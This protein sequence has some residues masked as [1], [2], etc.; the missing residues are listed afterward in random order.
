VNEVA[1]PVD[2]ATQRWGIPDALIGWVVVF[3]AA[4]IWAIV[5]IVATGHADESFDEL[6][7][8]IVALVQLGL[9]TGFF[10]VPWVV[11]KT[12]GNGM[13]AD[14]GVRATWS[15][16]GLGV[17]LGVILQFLLIP[18]YW[19][20]LEL[21]DKS[22]DDLEG[23]AESLTDRANTPIDVIFLV[24]IVGV[25]A[26]IFEEIFYRGLLQRALL[27]RGLGPVLS[28]GLTSVFFGVTHVEPLQTVGLILA[29]ALFGTLAYRTGRLGPAIAAHVGF[30]MVTVI[31]LLSAA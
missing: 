11:T 23:V 9:A 29:G 18:V 28:V 7:L 20:I 14:L 27:K 4:N 22:Y 10:V 13:V 5:V 31:S 8:A 2:E 17:P 19:P 1:T 30:N 25:M 12:K 16:I 24:L 3:L 26:P 6:P 21:L 15:D